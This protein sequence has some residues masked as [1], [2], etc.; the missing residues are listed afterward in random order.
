MAKFHVLSPAKEL[1]KRDTAARLS[2]SRGTAIGKSAAGHSSIYRPEAAGRV[3]DVRGAVRA[4]VAI[5]PTMAAATIAE[6]V[7]LA[8]SESL[9]RTKVAEFSLG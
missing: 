6:R 7:G 2:A 8:G 4:S 1:S 3:R 5:T 9:L